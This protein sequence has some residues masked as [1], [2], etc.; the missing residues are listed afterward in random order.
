M[1]RKFRALFFLVPAMVALAQQPSPSLSPDAPFDRVVIREA[2]ELR[3]IPLPG[4]LPPTVFGRLGLIV[5]GVLAAI[6]ILAGLSS[7]R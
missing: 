2:G 5:P 4:P 3:V 6:S 7:R 1:L